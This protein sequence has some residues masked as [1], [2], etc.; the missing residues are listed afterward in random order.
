M[1]TVGL[2]IPGHSAEEDYPRLE[3]LLDSDIRMPVVHTGSAEP[4][5]AD[6]AELRL[7]GAESVVWASTSGSF[8]YGWEGAH[9]QIRELAKAAGLPASSTSFGFVHAVRK[10]GAARVA[11]AATYPQDKADRFTGFLRAAGVDVA[12]TH[13]RGATPAEVAGWEESEVLALAR[14]G[15]HPQADVVLL[16]DTAL[17]TVA[18]LPELEDALGKPVLTATQVTV[19]EGLRLADRRT[20]ALNVGRLFARDGREADHLNGER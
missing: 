4:S 1:T 5:E 6:S 8:D 17:H 11:V 16:P 19:W 13:A 12:A 3:V 2:L 9:R 20:W 18:Y 15:D 10:L 7:G 14:A